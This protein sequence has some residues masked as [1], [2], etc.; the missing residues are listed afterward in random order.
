MI[1]FLLLLLPVA[2]ASG[3]YAARRSQRKTPLKKQT[4]EISPVYFKGLNFLLNEQPDKAIDLFIKMLDVDS[5]TVETH[6]ALGSL[7]RRRGEVDRAIRIHQNL[8]ARPS[9]NREQRAQALLELGQDYMTAGLYDRA[10]NLFLE[11]TDM[12]LF[13]EQAYIK[14]LEI[15]QQEKDWR[16]C[17]EVSTYISPTRN[18]F[19]NN[20]I[21]HFYCELAED[22]LKQQQMGAAE[23][24]LKQALQVSRNHLRA[25]M[26][27]GE[28]E[29]A[30]GDC[31]GVIKLFKKIEEQHRVYLSEILPTMV[32][33]YRKLGQQQ[34]LYSYLQESYSRHQCTDAVLYLAEM[35]AEQEGEGA[36]LELILKHLSEAPDLKGLEQLVRLSL[37]RGD[38]SPRETLE[39]LL[40]SVRKIIENQ[41]AFQCEQCGYTAKTLHWR[42][43]SCKTWGS[44]KP[45]QGLARGLA[46][47]N[48]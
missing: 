1:E 26:L 39:V 3:W 40:Q 8:I 17:L 5:D 6:L 33:C 14:L 4:Q 25:T 7:F 19:L 45:L 44:I 32:A 36:A 23:N 38:E 46:K 2:A 18:P 35:T 20:A 31:K 9:L 24:Y 37:Q 10:E 47:I 16:R 27:Q 30:R 12:K 21:A 15:Y 29:L 43:P 11:L 48:Q 41:P 34:E 13:S 22:Q 28:I 42:C